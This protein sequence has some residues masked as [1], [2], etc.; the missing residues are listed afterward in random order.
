MNLISRIFNA[1]R[2]TRGRPAQPSASGVPLTPTANPRTYFDTLKA[3][4]LN[5][6]LYDETMAALRKLRVWNEP[7]KPLRNPAMRAVE[8]YAST[9]WPGTLPAA[10]EV[11]AD[12]ARI[13]EPIQQI[14]QWSN[15]GAKKQLAAR[16]LALYG[17]LFLK[18][19]QRSDGRPYLQL[20]EPQD[21]TDFT[22]DERG[23]IT[24]L[25]IDTPLARDEEG[26]TVGYTRT[27]FWSKAEGE[28]RVYEHTLGDA[29]L[30]Q[31]EP[32]LLRRSLAEFGIDFVP[33]AFARLRDIGDQW[34][35]GAFALCLDKIDE[36]NRMATRLH[37]MLF[38]HNKVLWA[39]SANATDAQGRPLPAPRVGDATTSPNAADSDVVNLADDALLRLPGNATM[40]S[41]VPQL[42]YMAA[43]EILR[44]HMRELESDLPELT[45]F[46]LRD[47]GELSGK[48]VRLMLTNATDR[49]IEARGNAESALI[50]AQQMA[51][52]IGAQAGVFR[53]IGTYEAGDFTHAFKPRPVL[54]PDTTEQL[55]D[56]VLKQS[57]GVPDRQL[58]REAGYTDADRDEWAEW[59][60]EEAPAAEDAPDEA[61]QLLTALT[62]R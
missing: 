47:F 51:L 24:E 16:W 60:A 34:G 7:M 22:L 43:L 53:D 8:F 18:V 54:A 6:A 17:N 62:R 5:N 27:E 11:E 55:Q 56:L 19:S 44:D 41:L 14:H 21:V 39:L 38:R 45:Y 28:Y 1:L 42:N 33:I 4:Y 12:N 26:R 58:Q 31:L 23:F 52:T 35:A 49:T 15:W 9:L 2:G 13:V 3:Y 37:Q 46:R 20:I 36:A 59:E 57:I 25:R 48:A 61:D 50:Q 29:P 32:P 40:Q 10:L 30:A